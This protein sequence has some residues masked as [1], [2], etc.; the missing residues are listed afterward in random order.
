V[1]ERK[2]DRQ[3]INLGSCKEDG[4]REKGEREKP[5]CFELESKKVDKF[6]TGDQ[7]KAT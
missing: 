3:A 1:Y 5:C 6:S 4:N 2:H 7:Q